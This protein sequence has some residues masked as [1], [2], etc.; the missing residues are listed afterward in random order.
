MANSDDT[1]ARQR[2]PAVAKFWTLQAVR[3]AGLV[4]VLVGLAGTS[5]RIALP[6]WLAALILAAG[7]GTFFGLPVALARKWK[8]Q[9]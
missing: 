5:G 9:R 8:A 1:R 2:D 6:E 4:M 7:V 3:V